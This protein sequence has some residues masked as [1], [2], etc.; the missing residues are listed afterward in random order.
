MSRRDLLLALACAIVMGG[1]AG[2]TG[3]PQATGKGAVR[4]I[5]AIETAPGIVYLIEERTIGT[6]NFKSASAANEWDDLEYTFNFEVTLAGNSTRTRIA[7]QFIDVVVDTDYTIVLTGDLA[8]PDVTLWEAPRRIFEE[9]ETV[10]EARF[11]H[12]APEQPAVDVYFAAPGV[13]PAPGQAIGTIALGEVLAPADYEAGNY[14]L[15]LTT[16][17]DPGD[18]LFTSRTLTPAA[19]GSYTFTIFN[20]DANDV[21]PVAVQQ[22]STTGA[23]SRVTDA[24]FPPR[25]QLVQASTA[26]ATADVYLEDNG[27]MLTAPVVTGHAFRDITA[28]LPA[29]V[30]SNFLTY[31]TP[32]EPAAI[33]FDAE[34]VIAAGSRNRFVTV[35]DMDNLGG[36]LIAIDERS[37]ETVARVSLLHTALNHESV[38]VFLVERDATLEGTVPRFTDVVPGSAVRRIELLAGAYDIYLTPTGDAETVITGP[39]PLDV[40]FGDVVDLVVFDNVG[41]PSTADIVDLATP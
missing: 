26:L 29:F 19:P 38:D 11:G 20:A 18:V 16:A 24:G 2:E 5:N 12:A 31:T 41:D 33:L 1:C 25:L 6:I 7:S 32:M 9:G 3:R 8:A 27:Y 17:G 35:G 37:I 34:P 14:V 15:T 22:I 36:L 4:A 28:E 39:F 23:S 10:F 21:A 30:G 13:A 40:A